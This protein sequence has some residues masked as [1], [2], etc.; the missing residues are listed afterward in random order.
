MTRLRRH[1]FTSAAVLL[2]ALV[3][4]PRVVAAQDLFP[5][6]P[7]PANNYPIQLA[8]GMIVHQRNVVVFKGQNGT[9]ITFSIETPTP[10]T[11]SVR[12]AAEAAEIAKLLGDQARKQGASH[13]TIAFCR[14]RAC[15]E[16]R[17]AP[18]ERFSFVRATNGSWYVER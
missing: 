3:R 12:V 6:K 5:P 1:L 11:D 18:K 9:S 2:V 8:S 10:A 17:E 15:L 14:T 13:M 7:Y 16:L 4:Q